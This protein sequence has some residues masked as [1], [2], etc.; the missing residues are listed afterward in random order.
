MEEENIAKVIA[1]KNG[2][3]FTV[4]Q[5]RADRVIDALKCKNKIYVEFKIGSKIDLLINLREISHIR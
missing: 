3:Q 1:M 5:E 4:T 2:D